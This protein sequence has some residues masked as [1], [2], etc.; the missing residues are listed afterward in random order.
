MPKPNYYTKYK[1]KPKGEIRRE[2]VKY[3]EIEEFA[4]RISQAPYSDTLALLKQASKY[5]AGESRILEERGFE[6]QADDRRNISDL[7]EE[8]IVKLEEILNGGEEG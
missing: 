4:Q 2:P 3:L 6:K 5:F 8:M 7:F 1:S